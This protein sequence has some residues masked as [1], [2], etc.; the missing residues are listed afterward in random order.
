MC[1]SVFLKVF[2]TF[3]LFVNKEICQNGFIYDIASNNDQQA[4]T[5]GTNKAKTMTKIEKL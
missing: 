3:F 2:L 4:T 5:E 1:Q